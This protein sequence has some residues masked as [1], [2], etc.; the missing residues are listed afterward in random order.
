MTEEFTNTTND[1]VTV[2]DLK[3]TA[4]AK[5]E[6]AATTVKDR[7]DNLSLNQKLVITGAV[8]VLA[9][10]LVSKLVKSYRAVRIDE[11]DIVVLNAVEHTDDA[12]V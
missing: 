9:A 8:S 11:V 2:E 3:A 5:V 12:E 7:I 6:E 1:D 4:Q 10:A